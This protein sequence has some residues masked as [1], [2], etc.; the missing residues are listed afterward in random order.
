LLLALEAGTDIFDALDD[1][2]PVHP[3]NNTFPGEVFLHLAARAMAEGGVSSATP[4]SEAGL[5]EAHLPECEFRG[6]DNHKIR[7]AL[8]A[9]AA[10]HA[11]VEVD[12]LDEVV[13][14]A[15]D[16]LLEL[17]RVRRRRLDPRRGRVP[18]DGS[19]RPEPT[20]PRTRP[21]AR[22]LTARARVRW[23]C[24][25]HPVLQSARTSESRNRSLQSSRPSS[26]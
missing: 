7:Y 2:R 24:P 10:I 9:A 20:H 8:L 21:P 4:I 26:R 6:R 5:I 1:I 23:Q 18:R 13:D 11:G 16:G 14:W 22:Q 19:R 25:P 12:L 15:T 17:R 3:S